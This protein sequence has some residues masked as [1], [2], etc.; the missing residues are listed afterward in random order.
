[1]SRYIDL[2]GKNFGRLK[3]IKLKGKN[4]YRAMLWECKC[5]CGKKVIVQ[6]GHLRSGST[7]SCGCLDIEKKST[8]NGL[9]HSRIWIIYQNIIRRCND[10][11]DSAYH[12]YGGRGIR[13]EWKSFN[14]FYEDMKS[15][16]RDD[17]T[18][19]RIDNNGNYCKKNCRW[20][21]YQEQA[22]N[23]RTNIILEFNGKKQTVA[24]W[25]REIDIN[26]WT[27]IRRIKR[28]WTA[29]KALT[30]KPFNRGQNNK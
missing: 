3:V 21:T 23:C 24:Q 19:D 7:K 27:L 28:G 10:K 14:E 8:C 30:A 13:C 18:I 17:L 22:N 4:K 29:E 12:N 20:A 16:Y 1:M 9:S 2:Q 5:N 15:G 26:Y 11:N 25:A 6:S